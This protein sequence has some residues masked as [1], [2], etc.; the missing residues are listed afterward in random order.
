MNG[1]QVATG[2]GS[3]MPNVTFEDHYFGGLRTSYPG[4]VRMKYMKFYNRALTEAEVQ[5]L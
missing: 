1:T 5:S 3:P 2:L 4:N